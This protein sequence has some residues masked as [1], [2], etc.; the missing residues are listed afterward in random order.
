MD[1]AA[2]ALERRWRAMG[3]DIHVIVV[4]GDDDLLHLAERR[5]TELEQRWSRFLPDSEVSRLNAHAGDL[6]DTSDDTVLLVRRAIEAWRVTG[7]GFDPTL[8]DALRRAGYDRSF[9]DVQLAPGGDVSLPPLRFDRPGVTDIEVGDGAVRLPAGC[10]FDPGGIGKGLAADLVAEQLLVAGAGGALVNMGGDVRVAGRS[11][12]GTGWTLGIEHPWRNGPI[13]L[14]GLWNGAV[15]TSTVL[16][17]TWQ[18]DGQTRHHLIDPATGAPSTSDVAL[19]SV[20]GGDTWMAEVLAKAALL[21]GVARAFDLLDAAQAG[22]VVDHDG[23]VHVSA[24]FTSFS[25]GVVPA[26]PIQHTREHT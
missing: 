15:A 23:V 20:I 3:S 8:L 7:G 25:G 16:K 5:I 19:A 2:P 18:V 12:S 13:A 26:S 11:P 21:R 24:T 1:T 9:D 22:L 14:V 6:V 4:D 10:G 17:R